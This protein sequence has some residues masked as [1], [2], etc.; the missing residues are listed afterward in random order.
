[1]RN[2][3]TF[4]SP[5]L[6]ISLTLATLLFIITPPAVGA[7]TIHVTSLGATPNGKTDSSKAFL[8]AWNSACG[9]M[10]ASAITVP[11]GQFLMKTALK[12][13]GQSCKSGVSVSDLTFDA[14]GASLLACK[15]SGNGCPSD[16]TLSHM[17]TRHAT[18]LMEISCTTLLI[19]ILSQTLRF[20]NSM[21]IVINGITSINNQL[22]HI[23]IDGCKNVNVQGVK[24]F[25]SGYSPNTDGIEVE[26]SRGITILSSNIGTDNNCVS[27]GEGTTNLWIED[28]KCGPGIGSLRKQANAAGMQNITVKTATFTST[29]DGV[30]IKSWGR[31]SNGFVRNVLFEHIIMVNAKNPIIINQNY[32]RDSNVKINGVTH[33]DI[34]G[35]SATPVAVKF[36]CGPKYH[37]RDIKLEDKKLTYKN[38]TTQSS[39]VNADGSANGVIY[40][41]CCF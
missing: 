38:Q 14:K 34:H 16:A 20:T 26:S 41:K 17:V 35:S 24:V 29:N 19:A 33:Q 31:P 15:R 36:H 12:F 25:A 11:E 13:N 23:V 1:M 28:M 4:S 6:I 37:C 27:I 21:N 2:M 8:S 30:R 22:Y 18:Q 39:C 10:D 5:P 3:L 32:C 9:S 40:P 7:A